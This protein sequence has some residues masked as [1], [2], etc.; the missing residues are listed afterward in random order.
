MEEPTVQDVAHELIRH[1]VQ[2]EERWKT[3]FSRLERIDQ[4][5][6]TMQERQLYAIGTLVLFLGGVIVTLAMGV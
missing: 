2:C 4:K 5:L 6:E 1:E 3:T